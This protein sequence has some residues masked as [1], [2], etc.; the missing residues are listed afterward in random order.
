M[1]TLTYVW[2]SLGILT[3][4]NVVSASHNKLKSDSCSIFKRVARSDFS[5]L[6][7]ALTTLKAVSIPSDG[8]TYVSVNIVVHL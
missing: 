8:H 5:V 2:P 4:V 7:D 3:A 1:F 6:W